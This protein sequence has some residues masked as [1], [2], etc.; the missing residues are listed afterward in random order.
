MTTVSV[1][2]SGVNMENRRFDQSKTDVSGGSV[3]LLHCVL[4]FLAT[5]IYRSTE[6]VFVAE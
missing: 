1:N 5:S 2:I 6:C 3:L 4:A